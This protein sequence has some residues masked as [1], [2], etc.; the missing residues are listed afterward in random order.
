[1][2]KIRE[3]AMIILFDDDLFEHGY[4]WVRLVKRCNYSIPH[5]PECCRRICTWWSKNGQNRNAGHADMPFNLTSLMILVLR[6][7]KHVLKMCYN[8][9]TQSDVSERDSFS[10][11]ANSQVRLNREDLEAE[12]LKTLFPHEA[13]RRF[14]CLFRYRTFERWK[15]FV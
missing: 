12:Y 15:R 10:S 1:M 9:F 7:F 8:G 4:F 3:V 13:W 11:R 2:Y 6:R 5:Q 14:C